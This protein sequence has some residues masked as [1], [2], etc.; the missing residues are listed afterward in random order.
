MTIK[1]GTQLGS[2]KIVSFLGE[3][4]MGRVF[5][6]HDT[7]LKRDVAIKVLPDEFSRDADRIARFQREA[8]ALAALNHTNIAGIHDFVRTE[9][10]QFLVLELVEGETL[11]ERIAREPLPL[12]EV[13]QI[14][15]QIAEALEEAHER[16]IIHR[17]LKPANIKVTPDGKVKVLDF[18][19]AKIWEPSS[20]T[21]PGASNSPTSLGASAP[22]LIL[23][24][25]SYMSPEQARGKPVDRAADVWAFAC[26]LYEMLS[27]RKTFDGE[28]VTD[29]LGAI[30]QAEPDWKALPKDVPLHVSRLLRRCLE[31][32]RGMRLRDAGAVVVELKTLDDL[33][34]SS[35]KPMSKPWTWMIT[36]TV[37]AGALTTALILSLRSTPDLPET[38]VEINTPSTTD[39]FALG[40]SPDGRKIFS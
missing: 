31:K 39:E 8:E 26:V 2:Y 14:A 11:A 15:T 17:D 24:T 3:G 18:G 25:A 23:G 7:K 12:N 33:T 4:G 28:T 40:I 1:A 32:D 36:T 29:I 22:G 10:S 19:L 34:A 35:A 16:G 5:R 30:M 38:R 20:A 27:R 6:A 13:L 37:L 9:E 21:M